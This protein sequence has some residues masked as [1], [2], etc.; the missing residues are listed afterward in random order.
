MSA[1]T[2]AYLV[3]ALVLL[4]ISGALGVLANEYA[5]FDGD[6][7]VNRW[8]RELGPSF[9]F[10]AWPLNELDLLFAVVLTIA[11]SV[12]LIRRGDAEALGV[13]LA[14]TAMRPLVSVVKQTVDRPRPQGDFPVLDIVGDPSFPSGHVAGAATVLGIWLIFAHRLVPPVWDPWVR[15]GSVAGIVLMA[16]ARMWAGVHWFS[17]TY[18]AVVWVAALFAL[19]LAARRPLGAAVRTAASYLVANDAGRRLRAQLR[20]PR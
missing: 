5:I 12:L 14:V 2:R 8:A 11:A 18:G 13:A 1:E 19:A 6:V 20:R 4:G 3:A 10:V 7:T 16:L 17:D 9:R 15:I